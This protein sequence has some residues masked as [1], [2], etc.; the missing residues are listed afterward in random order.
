MGLE[1]AKKRGWKPGPKGLPDTMSK[2]RWAKIEADAAN[3][4]ISWR[5]MKEKYGHSVTT[6]RKY[7]EPIRQAA[8]DELAE[9]D[10]EQ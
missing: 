4:M 8:L 9:K 10:Q 1:A 7:L 6:L 3:P 2:D 5:V